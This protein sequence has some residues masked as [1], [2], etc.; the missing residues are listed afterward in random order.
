MLDFVA[1]AG[2]VVTLK[3]FAAK[4][5]TTERAFWLMLPESGIPRSLM[6]IISHGFGQNHAYYS[7]KG[8]SNPLSKDL[9][10]DVR[11]RFIFQRWGMQVAAMR[12]DMGLLFPVR[13]HAGG[14]EL[15]PFISQASVGTAIISTIASRA[16]ADFLLNAVDVCTFSSGIYDANTFIHTGGKGLKFRLMVNQDP[17]NGAPI[18]SVGI[19]KQYLSGWTTGGPRVGFEFLPKPRWVNDPKFAQMNSSLGRE[20]LHTWALPTYT[21]AMA[22]AQ[23]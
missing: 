15:G 7:K 21:L 17:S 8:Y 11:D 13:A 14:S 10:I 9:L 22:L 19:R 16:N 4:I 5:G 2:R 20:Y 6:V 12:A 3:V 18:A 1:K 23:L